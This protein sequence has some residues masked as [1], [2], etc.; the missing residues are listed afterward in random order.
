MECG[1]KFNM[2]STGKYTFPVSFVKILDM[3]S[4]ENILFLRIAITF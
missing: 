4:A 1:I 3:G 2:K